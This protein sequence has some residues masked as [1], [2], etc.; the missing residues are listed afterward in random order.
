MEHWGE[1]KRPIARHFFSVFLSITERLGDAS[2]SG[3]SGETATN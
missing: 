1:V 2:K 3:N